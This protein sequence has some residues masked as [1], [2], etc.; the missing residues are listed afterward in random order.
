MDFAAGRQCFGSED[1]GRYRRFF[2]K[3]SRVLFAISLRNRQSVAYLT[4]NDTESWLI[5]LQVNLP[6]PARILPLA[7][8]SFC[9]LPFQTLLV[10]TL[11]VRSET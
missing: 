5:D 6:Q 4:H 10:Y 7:R 3:T 9:G 11:F 8:Q 2:T 1:G